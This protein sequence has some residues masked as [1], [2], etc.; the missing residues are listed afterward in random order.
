MHFWKDMKNMRNLSLILSG[1]IKT[2][3]KTPN[4]AL[5]L[6]PHPRDWTKFKGYLPEQIIFVVADGI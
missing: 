6:M 4:I 5:K 1:S 3:Q 2:D